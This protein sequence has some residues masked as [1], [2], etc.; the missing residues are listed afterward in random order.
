MHDEH[1]AGSDR[2]P[3]VSE[4]CGRVADVEQQQPR[5]DEI[6]RR[7]RDRCAR[8]EVG[9]HEHA[10]PVPGVVQ[11][12]LR[13]AAEVGVDVDAAD[14]ARRPDA[15]GHQP[16]RLPG[17]AARVQAARPGG[18]LHAVEQLPGRGLPGASLHAQPLVL[19]RRA[20]EDVILVR[21]LVSP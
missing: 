1:A 19:L 8:L 6:E 2:V 7:A 10:L 5:V 4:H 21:G 3:Q 15:L 20:P 13:L 17:A 18:K 9:R 14:E 11:H 16:H 12:A